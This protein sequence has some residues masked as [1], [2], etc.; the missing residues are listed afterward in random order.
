MQNANNEHLCSYQNGDDN[1]IPV[2][3]NASPC[4]RS[5][6]KIFIKPK[7]KARI[8]EPVNEVFVNYDIFFAPVSQFDDEK[9]RLNAAT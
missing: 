2:S 7:I 5:M 6:W 3:G 9:F 4:I 1:D 8:Y